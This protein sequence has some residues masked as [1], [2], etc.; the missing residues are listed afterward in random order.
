MADHDRVAENVGCNGSPGI[1]AELSRLT[2]EYA[3][4]CEAQGLSLGSA[5][6]HLDDEDLSDAQRTWLCN[7]NARWEAASPVHTGRGFV[8]Q[9]D[10]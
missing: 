3:G 7:F 9:G 10:L 4:W 5:D 6:E 1:E 2:A 8:R